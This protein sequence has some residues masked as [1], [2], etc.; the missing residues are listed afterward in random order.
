MWCRDVCVVIK[1][2]CTLSQPRRT[3]LAC[4]K[5]DIKF[6]RIAHRRRHERACAECNFCHNFHGTS[7]RNGTMSRHIREAHAVQV[8]KLGIYACPR[9]SKS[10]NRRS[11]LYTHMDKCQSNQ[12]MIDNATRK[13]Q[14]R[15]KD[16]ALRARRFDGP[17]P[18]TEYIDTCMEGCDTLQTDIHHKSLTSVTR[19]DTITYFIR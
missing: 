3:R 2:H 11:K 19:S 18:D 13:T 7:S 8:S 17:L 6:R 1:V 9:C 12:E 15:T 16:L 14:K 4:N 10:F 5:C